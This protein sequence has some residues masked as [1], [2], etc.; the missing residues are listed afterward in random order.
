MVAPGAYRVI[1]APR[2]FDDLGRILDYIKR[3]SP[4][5]A[6]KVIDRLWESM[7]RLRELPHRYRVVQAVSRPTRA[8]RRMPVKPFLVYYRV[9][10]SM[11]LVRILTVTHGSQRQPR[12]FA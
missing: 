3:D 1:V 12:R 10:E 8:V 7:R 11:R 5:N 9:D 6:A 4:A 2:A